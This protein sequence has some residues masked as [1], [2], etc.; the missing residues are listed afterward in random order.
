MLFEGYAR[1]VVDLGAPDAAPSALRGLRRLAA[2]SLA[3]TRAPL[4][5]VVHLNLRARKP[6]EPIA[7]ESESARALDRAVRELIG[8]PVPRVVESASIP[9]AAE[10]DA[11][12]QL[13]IKTMRGVIVAGPAAADQSD[14]RAAIA[15]LVK[16]TGFPLLA[17]APSQV[18]FGGNPDSQID[19]FDWLYQLPP[20][21]T[22]WRPDLVIQLGVP[23]T[24]GAWERFLDNNPGVHRVVIAPWGWPDPQST[25]HTI[26]HAPIATA[27]GL[28]ARTIPDLRSTAPPNHFCA[29]LTGSQPQCMGHYR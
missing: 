27:C 11:L 4:P 14:A 2:Q 20:A 15:S 24:S 22:Q 29:A 26:L 1:R 19:A 17:E 13:C 9:D 16:A 12:A 23:P 6:L 18:R 10:I 3:L 21:D 5:G 25:A 7:P 28:L 8:I